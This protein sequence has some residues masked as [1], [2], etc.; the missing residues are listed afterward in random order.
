M[1]SKFY[2]LFSAH[3]NFY[4]F[5]GHFLPFAIFLVL[6]AIFCQRCFYRTFSA[7]ALSPAEMNLDTGRNNYRPP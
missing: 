4:L 6:P 1:T 5:T 2:R 7:M 3:G